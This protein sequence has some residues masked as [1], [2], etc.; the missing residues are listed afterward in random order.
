MSK[1]I[2]F[3]QQ[4][5]FSKTRGFLNTIKEMR[6][7]SV[8]EMYGQQGVSILQEATPKK[9]GAT[10]SAWTYETKVTPTEVSIVWSNT[11][12]GSDGTTPVALLIQLGH[13]TRNGGYVP[14]VD[15]I[16]P[17]MKPFFDEV[18]EAVWRVVTSL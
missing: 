4:G 5:D 15:Y 8:L 2:E 11:Q 3:H 10:A 6:M 7:Y 18:A 14:P 9:T 1:I 12:M 16:N 17:A 13:G